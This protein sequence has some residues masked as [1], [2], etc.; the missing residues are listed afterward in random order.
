MEYQSFGGFFKFLRVRKGITL[1]EF[2]LRH[3]LDPGN[4]SKLER[5]MLTPPQDIEKLK[6]YA[7]YLDIKSGSKDWHTFVDL[8][9]ASAGKIPADI[10]GD[11][12]IVSRLPIFFRTLR[13]KK[14]T[15][16]ALKELIEKIK[17]L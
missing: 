7:N 3:E 16:E 15:K 1:R 14:L 9:S 10:M 17:G 5:G 8:A 6:E 12:E 2:C 11:K 4:L 13:N